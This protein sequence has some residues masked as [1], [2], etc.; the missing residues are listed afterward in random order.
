MRYLNKISFINSAAVKYAELDLNGN[1]HF[2]GTQGVGKSTLLRAIL[3]FYNA[4]SLKLGVPLGPTSKSFAEWYFPYQNSYIVY[5]V[6]RETGA[7]S[8]MAF[9]A[10]NRVCFYFI[11]APYQREMFIDVDGRAFESW[12]RIR[13]GLDAS[14]I[15]YSRRIKSFEEYR[16][17]LYGNNQGKKEFQRYNLL[18]SRQ[19]LNIPRT[20][21]NVFLNSKL[22][23]EFI[24]QTIIDSMGEEELQI[25]LQIYAHHLKDFEAQLNDIQQFRQPAVRKQAQAAAQLY[26]AINHLQRQRREYVAELHSALAALEQREPLLTAKLIADE[27]RL[28][29]IL[30]KIAKE[31]AAFERR[32]GKYVAALIIFGD[33][34]KTAR[35]KKE[36]YDKLNI[37]EILER[38]GNITNL[39]QNRANLIAEKN[40]LSGQFLEIAQKY[41]ALLTE[42]ENQFHNF[43]NHKEQEKLALKEVF[44]CQRNEITAQYDQLQEEIRQQ[45]QAEM[46]SARQRHQE[47]TSQ[48]YQLKNKLILVKKQSFYVAEIEQQKE[49]LKTLELKLQQAKLQKEANAARLEDLKR[50]GELEE[51]SLSE[52]QQRKIEQVQQRL[53][54]KLRQIQVIGGKLNSS[55]SALYGWLNQNYAG[56]EEHIGKVCDEELLFD[57]TLAPRRLPAG[58]EGF[59]GVQLDLSQRA[60]KVKSLVDYKHE[61]AILQ[62]EVED[63]QAKIQFLNQTF[64]ADLQKLKQRLHPKSRAIRQANRELDYQVEQNPQQSE[65]ARLELSQWEEKGQLEKRRQLEKLQLAL[66]EGTEAELVAQQQLDKVAGQLKRQLKIK[67]RERDQNI[68]VLEHELNQK[69]SDIDSVIAAK[70]HDYERRKKLVAADKNSELKVHGAD[71]DRLE[72]IE[73]ELSHI[74]VELE[75]VEAKRDLVAEYKQDKR[76]LFDK[77]KDFKNQQQ[78]LEREQEQKRQE[79]EQHNNQRQQQR[80]DLNT[81]IGQHK[82]ALGEIAADRLAFADFKRSE[83]FPLVE[84]LLAVQPEPGLV[85]TSCSVV[86][87]ALKENYYTE[88]LRQND[89]REVVDKFLGH[90]SADNIF[91]FQTRFTSAAAYLDFSQDLTEFIEEDKINEFEKRINERFAEI[92]TGLGKE[93]TDLVSRTGKI[94]KVISK[95]NR[96][97]TEKNFVGAIGSIELKLDESANSVFVVLRQIK[98]FNDQHDMDFGSRDLFS[99]KNHELNNQKAVALLRALMREVEAA[100]G[101]TITLADSF[102][103]KFRIEENQNDTGWVEKLS[104]VGSDGTD[105]LVKAMVN[106]MLLN[107]FKEGA[108]RR[109][110]DFRLHCIMDEIGKLHPNNIRGIIKF[111][112]DR[113]IMLINGSPTE[114]NALNYKHVFKVSKD[115]SGV[116]RVIRI[117]TN[118]R[119]L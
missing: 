27:Q 21:Q 84:E 8:I 35:K 77:L 58:V 36:H 50:S 91:K 103:L 29:Q 30:T 81:V 83:V 68:A 90:F 78:L 64:T 111:A 119:P 61:Q 54:E 22:D 6:K 82:V 116:T 94:Q 34:I 109:F 7:Y 25:D 86:I 1:I 19:Y 48:R 110:R 118:N 73:K 17:I 31:E 26:V 71:T 74:A 87:D 4:N 16:D 97:F 18:E 47:L 37:A 98:E 104:H 80:I 101:S 72:S 39:N 44:F 75:F 76:D 60:K 59:Y 46:E 95:I 113:N 67:V 88:I 15:F 114:N 107:V 33:K 5:E 10:Q 55:H 20:I 57:A 69:V 56:W 24:K 85:E 43:C 12:D 99:T 63:L 14:N 93:T 89:L 70:H 49:I 112:N 92:V 106:I 23:A 11:D 52:S 96:D 45:H 62:R 65:L 38:V 13:S 102:E 28:Q 51:K 115:G 40:L 9:K 117:L 108:S 53:T 2:I 3:F 32:N 66:A 100:R 105:I 42:L 41:T 79:F